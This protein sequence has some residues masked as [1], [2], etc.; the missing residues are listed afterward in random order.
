MKYKF[1]T[2]RWHLFFFYVLVLA[3]F[4]FSIFKFLKGEENFGFFVLIPV[5][6]VFL[7]LELIIKRKKII[8]GDINLTFS[9]GIFSRSFKKIHYANITDLSVHQNILQRI[10]G[11]GSLEITTAGT[12][13][14]E[15]KMKNVVKLVKL[16]KIISEKMSAKAQNRPVYQQKTHPPVH[17]PQQPVQRPP[18]QR[19][20]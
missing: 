1:K 10:L 17:R 16:E 4:V 18:Q 14:A 13:E 9:E 5:V 2:S 15:V 20:R 6:V 3:G 11:F 12:S 19:R 8:L 7:I